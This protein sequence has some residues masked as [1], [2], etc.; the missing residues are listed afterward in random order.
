M[1]KALRWPD[2]ECGRMVGR[3]FETVDHTTG[4]RSNYA[5]SGGA[6]EYEP[7]HTKTRCRRTPFGRYSKLIANDVVSLSIVACI[8]M[9]NSDKE[10]K[11]HRN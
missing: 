8:Y 5:A 4:D 10:T 9:E 1:G 3:T 11:R 2:V 6:E 7:F